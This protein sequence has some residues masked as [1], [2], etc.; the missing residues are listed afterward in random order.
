[1]QLTLFDGLLSN[2]NVVDNIVKGESYF[3]SN[4]DVEASPLNRPTKTYAPG[5]NWVGANRGVS[6]NFLNNTIADDVKIG[7]VNG[8]GSYG[9]QSINNNS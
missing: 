6:M 5:N 7:A 8:P 4:S 3:Y 9:L 1:M 2:I